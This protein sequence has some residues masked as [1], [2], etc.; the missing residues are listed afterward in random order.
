MPDDPLMT[1]E[2]RRPNDEGRTGRP[3]SF[4][5]RASDFLGGSLVGHSPEFVIPLLPSRYPGPAKLAPD[6]PGRAIQMARSYLALAGV[7]G[8]LV[9]GLAVAG[10]QGQS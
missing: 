6:E 1:K 10:G 3:S 8:V 2:G 5:F 4:R 7:L 9:V